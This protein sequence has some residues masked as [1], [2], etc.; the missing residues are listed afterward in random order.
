MPFP[1]CHNLYTV[2]FFQ[3]APYGN[4]FSTALRKYGLLCIGLYRL[5]QLEKPNVDVRY[6]ITNPTADFP[7]TLTDKVRFVIDQTFSQSHCSTNFWEYMQL[8]HMT[9]LA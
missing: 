6:V 5:V 3:N 4:L 8:Y 2:S 1:S 9:V 7:L